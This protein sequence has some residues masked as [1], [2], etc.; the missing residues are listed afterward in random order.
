[1]GK[2]NL[3]KLEW[4]GHKL[5][6]PHE[7]LGAEVIPDTKY[8]NMWRVKLAGSDQLSDMVN[9]TRARDA[10]RAMV[11]ARQHKPVPANGQKGQEALKQPPG[12]AAGA[13]AGGAR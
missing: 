11:M 6:G 9:Y 4:R 10:A 8:P 7:R 13:F 1:M 3:P 12:A 2:I 5:Y